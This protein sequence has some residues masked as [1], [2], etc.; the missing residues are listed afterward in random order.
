MK[1]LVEKTEEAR[2]LPLPQY[3]TTGSAGMDLYAC[4]PDIEYLEPGQTMLISTGLRISLPIGYEAQIRP[5]SGLALKNQVTILNTPGTIDSDYRGVIGV[6]LINF[7]SR[8]FEIKRGARI[9]QMVINRVER[10]E[11]EQVDTLDMTE[12]GSGGFGHTGEQPHKS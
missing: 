2:D 5:R 3:M 11:W 9:A 8:T 10:I 12:R 6:I 1:V 4:V 7:G